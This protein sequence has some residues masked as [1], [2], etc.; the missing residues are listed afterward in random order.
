[1]QRGKQAEQEP[2]RKSERQREQQHR[3]VEL[4]SERELGFCRHH[5]KHRDRR[6]SSHRH[7]ADRARHPE[8]HRFDEQQPHQPARRRS[9]R[10]SHGHLRRPIGGPGQQQIGDICAGDEQ[11]ETC[12]G[13]DQQEDHAGLA[14]IA[15]SCPRP[16][17]Q[18]DAA[19]EELFARAIAEVAGVERELHVADE[20]A[21]G[22]IER[23]L[24][25]LVRRTRLQTGQEVQVVISAAHA[26]RTQP[27]RHRQRREHVGDIQCRG[28]GEVSRRHAH[29]RHRLAVDHE[30]LAEHAAVGAQPVRPVAVAQHDD[31]VS[32]GH[33]IVV[34]RQQPAE[35]RRGAKRREIA[36]RNQQPFRA[37]ALARVRDVR[38]EAAMRRDA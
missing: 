12:D 30:R 2:G 18:D 14:A 29:D 24:G 23:S 35:R 22:A 3:R 13:E 6:T 20:R 15:D 21:E 4:E 34:R 9:H 33:T 19:R 28:A 7:R 31:G 32:A 26:S 37:A 1:M 17:L 38:R 36:A 11:D 16:V 10:Q 27:S 5:A 8:Q 25:L